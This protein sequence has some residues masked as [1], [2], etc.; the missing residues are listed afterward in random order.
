MLVTGVFESPER[1]DR[2]RFDC[3]SWLIVSLLSVL[4][5]SW[6]VNI[7]S[8]LSIFMN[9]E[10]TI[11]SELSGSLKLIWQKSFLPNLID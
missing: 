11:L 4:S 8:F 1:M 5:L 10:P 6:N 7:Y 9:R 2:F 3:L